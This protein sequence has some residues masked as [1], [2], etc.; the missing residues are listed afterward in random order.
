MQANAPILNNPPVL[1]VPP[2]IPAAVQFRPNLNQIWQSNY[3][4]IHWQEGWYRNQTQTIAITSQ[5]WDSN[6]N[7][8][9]V[10]GRWGRTN[11]NDAG[12]FEMIFS[13]ACEFS[14]AGVALTAQVAAGLVPVNKMVVA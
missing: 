2:G 6:R 5:G 11:S 1:N 12:P 3:G 8:Y 10:E 13:S 9:V 7:A 4:N 14:V